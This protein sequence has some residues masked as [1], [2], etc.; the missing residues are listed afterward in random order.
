ML[1]LGRARCIRPARG[2]YVDGY[3][4][5]QFDPKEAEGLMRNITGRLPEGDPLR[6]QCTDLR[7]AVKRFGP[8]KLDLLN[9]IK[10][11]LGGKLL[12]RK[13]PL[14]VRRVTA[15]VKSLYLPF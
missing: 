14:R 13:Q 5:L 4:V 2:P 7:V 12:P 6:K 10:A 9:K 15:Q 3:K 1:E 8:S 11:I